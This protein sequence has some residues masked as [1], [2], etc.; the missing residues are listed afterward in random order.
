[1]FNNKVLCLDCVDTEYTIECGPTRA[2][3]I[4]IVRKMIGNGWKPMGGVCIDIHDKE[5]RFVQAMT[6][7]KKE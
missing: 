7:D 5:H 1:M 2:D 6:R 4:R 3:L